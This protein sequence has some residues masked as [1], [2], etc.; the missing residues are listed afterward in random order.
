MYHDKVQGLIKQ[1]RGLGFF[2][3]DVDKIRENNE[4]KDNETKLKVNPLTSQTNLQGSCSFSNVPIGVYQIEVK[5]NEK[6]Q[7]CHRSINVIN[8][9]DKDEVVIFVCLKPRTNSCVTFNILS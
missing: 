4:K 2:G 5:G 8:D 9:E 3:D 7:T 6:F 1:G